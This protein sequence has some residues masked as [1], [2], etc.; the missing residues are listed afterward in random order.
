MD[1][2]ITYTVYSILGKVE[3]EPDKLQYKNNWMKCYP[4]FE[5]IMAGCITKTIFSV[6][7]YLTTYKIDS[8]G[9]AHAKGV[10]APTGGL[11]VFSRKNYLKVA[12]KH[13]D[14]HLEKVKLVEQSGIP[15]IEWENLQGMGYANL[16]FG[17]N[18]IRGWICDKQVAK[19]ES[20]A[21]I[22][23]LANSLD[24][25]L[26]KIFNQEVTL[27]ISN[28]Y[29]A[30]IGE[31]AITDFVSDMCVLVK[32]VRVGKT[33]IPASSGYLGSNFGFAPTLK[34]RDVPASTWEYII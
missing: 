28:E 27:Y 32:A 1:K 9:I 30:V 14:K 12:E 8:K 31:K 20:P 3:K 7:T 16:V 25:D 15:F 2:E 4:L 34:L 17:C 5:D 10:N 22:F 21:F 13:L 26:F 24:V 19:L 11:Q 23:I 33:I 18:D 6:Q 29:K